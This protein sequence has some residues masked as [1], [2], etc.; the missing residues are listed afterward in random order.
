MKSNRLWRGW[1]VYLP[2]LLNVVPGAAVN[3]FWLFPKNGVSGWNETTIGY[4]GTTIGFI[5]TYIAG[6]SIAKSRASK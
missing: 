2:L 4:V 5:I 6:V 1:I 3:Y